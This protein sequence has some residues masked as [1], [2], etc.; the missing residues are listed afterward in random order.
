[1]VGYG[2]IKMLGTEISIEYV[3]HV[4]SNMQLK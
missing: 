1:M 2:V 3:V 4:V